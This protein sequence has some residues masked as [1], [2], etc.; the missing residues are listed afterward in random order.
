MDPVIEL[1]KIII[2][3]GIV[4]LT[5]FYVIKNFLDNET[6]KRML[7]IKG[8]GKELLT[9]IRLQAYERIILFLERISPNSLVMRVNK[10]TITSRQLHSEL[11][12]AIRAEF[13]HNLSQQ[14]YMSA[15]A[16]E[17]VKNAKEETTKLI[18][19]LAIKV[20]E[21]AP[22]AELAQL[23]VEAGGKTKLPTQMAIE[24][25]KKEIAQNF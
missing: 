14:I 4:F 6:K 13:E 7:E 25:I 20:P 22:G 24:F 2:P 18:N 11:V 9:P 15:S 19:L 17:M 16:W 1:L 23:I 12:A 3:A 8:A 5:S 10:P 21:N